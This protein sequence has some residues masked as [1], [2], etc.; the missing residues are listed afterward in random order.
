MISTIA[1]LLALDENSFTIERI[2]EYIKDI[3]KENEYNIENYK[4]LLDKNHK[5]EDE[6]RILEN[7]AKEKDSQIEKLNKDLSTYKS[8]IC[9]DA[10]NKIASNYAICKYGY[11]LYAFECQPMRYKCSIVRQKDYDMLV[12]NLTQLDA[13][14]SMK[15]TAKVSYP[16]CEKI[17]VFL[18]K[19][20]LT[21][22]GNNT[23]EGSIVDIKKILDITFQF[24]KL[25]IEKGANLDGLIAI[26]QNE[27][28]PEDDNVG[29]KLDAETPLVRKA[30]RS[31]DQINKDT[32]EVIA[33]YESIEA[34][35]RATGLTTGTAIGIALR[36]KRQCKGFL[37]R[38]SG[39]SKEDQF[40]EQPVIKI[41]CKTGCHCCFKTIADAAKDCGVSAPAMR[42]RI[43]TN[44]HAN[45]HHWIFDKNSSHYN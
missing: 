19:Q 36:E 15:H 13:T 10:K 3:I 8:D 42:Q 28:T 22:I 20:S 4:I 40:S 45:D 7:Q 43:L 2:D 25:L 37:W 5:L 11:F 26:L 21:G 33:T 35:G 1:E 17:M 27:S 16:L 23:Y 41:N 6:I 14:G 44:V 30:K 18:L 9:A 31:I 29:L 32:G 38:Y 34:A 12:N 39:V 24:E